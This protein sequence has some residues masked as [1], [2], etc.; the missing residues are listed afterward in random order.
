MEV[1]AELVGGSLEPSLSYGPIITLIKGNWCYRDVQL[2]LTCHRCL[3]TFNCSITFPPIWRLRAGLLNIWW[4]NNKTDNVPD[5]FEEYQLNLLVLTERWHADSDSV[6][7]RRIR[8]IGLNAVKDTREL[9]HATG[10]DVSHCT[11]HEGLAV[12]SKPGI[13]R[14][15]IDTKLKLKT[16]EHLCCGVGGR[17]A[18][19]ITV[20]IYMLGSQRVCDQ[21]FRDYQLC[22]SHSRHTTVRYWL[23]VLW[24]FTL[25]SRRTR[26]PRGSVGSLTG[27]SCANY[28]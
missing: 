26:I 24:I 10:D 19:L 23:S 2:A 27:S 3:F 28:T 13:N 11:N 16:F 4:V 9:S 21:F 18:P 7:L 1:V 20:V 5:L 17:H 15:K 14:A 6:A 12:V 25:S 22:W 8:C